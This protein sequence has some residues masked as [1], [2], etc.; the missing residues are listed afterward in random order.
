MLDHY[1]PSPIQFSC[2]TIVI[3]TMQKSANHYIMS[4]VQARKLISFEQHEEKLIKLIDGG[5]VNDF[6][7]GYSST[8]C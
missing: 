2:T 7:R 8:L 5:W 4:L 1:T 6:Y 3:K